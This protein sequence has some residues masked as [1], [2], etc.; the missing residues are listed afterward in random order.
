MADDDFAW[1]SDEEFGRQTLAGLSPLSIQL[2]TVRGFYPCVR[3]WE[4]KVYLRF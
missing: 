4:C 1:L 2:V 3:K